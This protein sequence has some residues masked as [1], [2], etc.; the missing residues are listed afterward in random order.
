M[1]V[2]CSDR[3]V[4]RA[5]EHELIYSNHVIDLYSA[6]IHLKCQYSTAEIQYIQAV[7]NN[8]THHP[9]DIRFCYLQSFE[10]VVKLL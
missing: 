8:Y 5:N 6:V 2:V 3:W 7:L 4:G 9:Q 10:L 1:C